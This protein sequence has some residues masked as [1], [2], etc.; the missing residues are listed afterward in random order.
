MSTVAPIDDEAGIADATPIAVA[1][2][3][4]R[5]WFGPAAALAF[6]ANFAWGAWATHTLLA[7]EDRRVVT[8]QL[9]RVM[10]EFI[11]AEAKS[12]RDP[13]AMRART[14]AYLA[15]TQSAVAEL[16]RDGTTVLVAEAVAGGA[17]DMTDALR[18]TVAKK[19]EGPGDGR[20]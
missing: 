7:L 11:E 2:P 16:G 9:A 1:P 3:S 17:P 12:G 8:V 13:E 6:T 19:L 4:S 14:A 20:R 5:I 18:R 10:G 15:A